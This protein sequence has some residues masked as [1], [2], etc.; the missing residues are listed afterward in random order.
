MSFA[1]SLFYLE[2]NMRNIKSYLITDP[3]YFSNNKEIFKEKLVAVLKN[4]KI[5]FAC[6]RDKSSQNIEE[7]AKIFLQICKEFKIK[8]ILINSNITLAT[9]LGFDG[10][11]H[12]EF[13]MLKQKL[14]L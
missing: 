1:Y 7:L 6:F 4:H 2:E 13:Q 3:N 11:R 9:K 12:K 5:D 8:N 10:Y 14:L